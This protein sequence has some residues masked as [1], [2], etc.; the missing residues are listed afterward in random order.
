MTQ[1]SSLSLGKLILGIAVFTAAGIPLVGYLWET[2]NQLL[3]GQ[4]NPHRL[5]I[6]LP[7]LLLLAGLL[8]LVSRTVR[9]WEAE[10]VDRV[11]P[12]RAP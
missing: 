2:L 10:R 3:A 11:S 12:P 5:L 4:V 8:V 1:Q 7:L 6:S 9:S